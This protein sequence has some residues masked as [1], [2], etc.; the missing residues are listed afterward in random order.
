MEFV[1]HSQFIPYRKFMKFLGGHNYSCEG[2]V[3]NFVNVGILSM[4]VGISEAIRV[5]FI[6]FSLFYLD[7]YNPDI[8]SIL[9]SFIPIT[10]SDSN[11]VFK[12]WLA[13]LIDGDGCFLLSKKGYASL[14]ITVETRDKEA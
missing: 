4:L 7:F 3:N 13:G 8:S 6:L 14:E 9:M 1:S 11:I 10:N 2:G 5:A 12:E